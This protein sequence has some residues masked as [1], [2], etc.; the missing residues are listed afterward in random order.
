MKP[1][2]LLLATVLLASAPA[3]AQQVKPLPL[4]HDAAACATAADRALCYLQVY[5][6]WLVTPLR[7]DPEFAARP[8]LLALIEGPNKE[9]VRIPQPDSFY[10][11][12]ALAPSARMSAA[13]LQALDRDAKGEAPDAAIAPILAAVGEL[14]SQSF[15]MGQITTEAGQELRIFG[16]RDVLARYNGKGPDDGRPP[17]SKAFVL[18]LLAEWEKDVAKDFVHSNHFSLKRSRE[19]LADALFEFGE[20]ARGEA[21][22]K[23]TGQSPQDIAFNTAI[24]SGDIDGAINQIRANIA[25]DRANA[26]R[27]EGNRLLPLL[28]AARKLPD[29][30]AAEAVGRLVFELEAQGLTFPDTLSQLAPGLPPSLRTELVAALEGVLARPS[31]EMPPLHTWRHDNARMTLARLDLEA[32]NPARMY[33]LIVAAEQTIK[34]C[35]AKD[36]D[37]CDAS[38]LMYLLIERGRPMDAK[39]MFDT[40]GGRA[41]VAISNFQPFRQEISLG[42]GTPQTMEWMVEVEM[43]RNQ[44]GMAHVGLVE[45]V[46]KRLRP[47]R[48]VFREVPPDHD[49]ALACAR[50]AIALAR[51]P[52]GIAV[53]EEWNSRLAQYG[54]PQGRAAAAEL[55]MD[56]AGHLLTT[57]PETAA[58]LEQTALDLWREAPAYTLGTPALFAMK[59]LAVAKLKAE[60]RF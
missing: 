50:R 23:L 51:D 11:R 28:I 47:E 40:P 3:V 20:R 8:E 38:Q 34:T 27:E 22:L 33:A 45:C 41:Y 39:A 53:T 49:A 18:R 60:G 44:Y 52:K 4:T 9:N 37:G 54:G 16:Y 32:G 48:P 25:A 13:F 29:T 14:P 10:T 15:A 6:R 58:E 2:P 19:S 1:K 43:A 17:P 55:A 30:R 46:A 31:T 12:A 26:R 21:A 57:R 5:S 56:L 24:R 59:K 36:R 42:V 7:A 35:D